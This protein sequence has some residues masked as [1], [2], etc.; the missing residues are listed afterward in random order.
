MEFIRGRYSWILRPFLIV[1]DLFIINC[2]AFYLLNFNSQELYFFSY[3]FFNNKNILYLFYSIVFW[4]LSTHFIN[5]YKVYRYTSLLNILSLILK[6]FFVYSILV[7]AFEGFFRSINIE[8]SVTLNY[9]IYTF[10]A[11]SFVKLLSYY[12]LKSIRVY[13]KGNLR[14]IIVIGDGE[15]VNALKKI[16]R[17]KKELG[18]NIKAVFSNTQDENNSGDIEDSFTYLAKNNDNI[19]EIY[20]SIADLSEKELNEYVRYANINHCNIKFIPNTKKLINKRYK[21]DYY[22]Y[23][24]V[25]S[26]QEVALN[27]EVNKFIKRVFD[28]V[29]AL[30]IIIFILPVISIILFVLIKL[31]SKGPLFYKHKRTGI[32]YKAFY[33]YKYRSLTTTQESKGT[34]VRQND[35]RVTTI[36]KFIRRTS[37]DELPQFVNVLKGEMSVVG[38]RPHMLTYTDDYSKKINKYNFIYRHNVKP[39]ITGLAQIKG[40]RGEIKRDEDIINRVKY[41]NFYIEN[42]SLLLDLKIIGQTIINVLKGDEKAY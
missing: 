14:N 7:Y 23:I 40:Y 22:N 18:Y 27:N 9:L 16:F 2:L 19:D 26:I 6:Q 35:T 29:F 13:L 34:Y 42:W 41:D 28:I 33:C 5:F 17:E 37:I 38:P 15:S 31:E 1:Y 21:T 36:G 24:P 20:C 30:L 11:I 10:L 12:I 32:N 3:E 25:L 4:L 39:G 8:V